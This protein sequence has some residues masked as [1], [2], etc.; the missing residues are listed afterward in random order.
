[1]LDRVATEDDHVDYLLVVL[2]AARVMPEA[3]FDV[4]ALAHLRGYRRIGR[5]KAM[6]EGMLLSQ[7]A[8]ILSCGAGRTCAGRGWRG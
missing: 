5:L 8:Y 6:K 1:M 4:L 7:E 2:F 3:R